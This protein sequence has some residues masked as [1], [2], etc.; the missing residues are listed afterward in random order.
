MLV[1]YLVAVVRVRGLG[2]LVRDLGLELRWIDLLI[3]VGLAVVV[4]FADVFIYNFAVGVLRLPVAP[5]SNAE[6]PRSFVWAVIVGLG[7]ASLIAPIVEELYF[8]GLLMRAVRNLVIRHARFEGTKTTRRATWISVVTSAVV[9][10]G[11]HLYEARN[12]TMLFVLGVD[13]L[14]FGLLAAAVASRTRRLGPSLIMHISTNAF[15][16]VVLLS[17]YRA[18]AAGAAVHLGVALVAVEVEGGVH[19]RD[20]VLD[21]VGPR[22]DRDADLAGRDHL[23]VDSGLEQRGEQLRR[24]TRVGAHARSDERQLADLVVLLQALETDVR[25]GGL[26]RGRVAGPSVFGSVNEMSVL[27]VSV[28]ETFCTIM[29]MLA[30]AVATTVKI[31]AALPGTSGTP[32]TVILAWLRSAAT[33]AMSGSSTLLSPSTGLTTRVPVLLLNDDRTCRVTPCL[34]AYSTARMYKTFAPA[35]ASSSIS[36]LVIFS[37]LRALRHHARIGREH[38]VDV[39]V[40]L[41]D[42]GAEGRGQG[43]RGRVGSPAAER[44]DVARA[45]VEA[46][47]PGD[48]GDRAGVEGLRTR[49]GVTSTMR[50]EPCCASVI[51]PAWLPV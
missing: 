4:H 47:E 21:G 38:A 44:R 34:R 51:M 31:C 48:D 37:I 49:P 50:A 23:D 16:T 9:F 6:L 33:P 2:S 8:R 24:D 41:A 11:F 35:A 46:L 40:D 19:D 3:G 13:I 43:D 36:S 12:P 30:P 22:D 1:A 42:V 27:A 18:L 29:S 7:I 39:G 15:A 25:F 17:T 5:T 32:T 45:A 28:R 10:A 14:V 26:E 20:S